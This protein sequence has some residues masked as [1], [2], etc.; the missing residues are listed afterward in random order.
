MKP[1]KLHL[2]GIHKRSRL[3]SSRSD[4]AGVRGIIDLPY[5]CVELA[6][7]PPEG[8]HTTRQVSYQVFARLTGPQELVNELTDTALASSEIYGPNLERDG[9]HPM[10]QRRL[11]ANVTGNTFRSSES[12]NIGY[13]LTYL[14]EVAL[15]IQAQQMRLHQVAHSM[16]V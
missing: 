9:S 2:V 10:L 5:L 1:R 6:W 16:F 7:D 12:D 11:L 3:T 15:M 4:Q 14:F 13:G 8:L